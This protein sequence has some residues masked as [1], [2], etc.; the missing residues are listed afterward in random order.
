MHPGGRKIVLLLGALL[1]FAAVLALVAAGNRALGVE[2]PTLRLGVVAEFESALEGLAQREPTPRALDVLLFGDS[3]MYSPEDGGA[4][5]KGFVRSFRPLRRGA[6]VR[7]HR[8]A[9]PGLDAFSFFLTASAAAREHPDA[10]VLAFNPTCFS[11]GW[12]RAFG[13]PALAALLPWSSVPAAAALPMHRIGLSTDEMLGYRLLASTVGIDRWQGIAAFQAR[14]HAA[15]TAVERHLGSGSEFATRLDVN[16]ARRREQAH[17]KSARGRT[18]M[19]LFGYQSRYAGALRHPDESHPTM[20]AFAATLDL[21]QRA[22][23]PTL[24][25]VTPLNVQHMQSVGFRERAVFEEV[26]ELVRRV[27]EERGAAFADLHAEFR[28]LAFRDEGDHLEFEGEGSAMRRLSAEIAVQLDR[29]L[30]A[31]RRERRSEQPLR[32]MA[33]ASAAPR[34]LH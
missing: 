4:F 2:T 25:Y 14:T 28:D 21:L 19:S 22:E 9:A 26:V 8:F 33:F 12:A 17:G 3:S 24:V 18:R 5:A 7:T 29:A 34:R 11:R 13:I 32:R 6:T 1:S 23:V 10:A 31:S 20:R 15:R 30:H 27:S 16:A